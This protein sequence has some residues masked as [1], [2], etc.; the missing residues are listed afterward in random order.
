M[1]LPP[2]TAVAPPAMA[3]ATSSLTRSNWGALLIGPS[4]ESGSAPSPTLIARACAARPSTT[5]SYSASG[6]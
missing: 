5:S 3:S 1:A 4:L 2:V 6:T